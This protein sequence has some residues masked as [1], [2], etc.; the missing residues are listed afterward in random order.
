[1]ACC[2]TRSGATPL[3][4][5]R[6]ERGSGVFGLCASPDALNALVSSY[7]RA[8]VILRRPSERDRLLWTE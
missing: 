4:G 3:P 8:V 6:A 7:G 1:M 2:A 5:C